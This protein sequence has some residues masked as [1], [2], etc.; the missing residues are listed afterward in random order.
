MCYNETG[1]YAIKWRKLE[2][3]GERRDIELQG[4]GE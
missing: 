3:D 1:W 2:R 4:R